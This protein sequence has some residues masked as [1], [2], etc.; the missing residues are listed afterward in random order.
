[1]QYVRVVE[2]TSILGSLGMLGKAETVSTPARSAQRPNVA[3]G[4]Q[5]RRS[6]QAAQ[7]DRRPGQTA[8]CGPG[9]PRGPGSP[10]KPRGPRATAAPRRPGKL[11]GPAGQ[12]IR[13]APAGRASP[14]PPP[15]APA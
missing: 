9:K 5:W 12:A 10:G 11:R 13:A 7:P 2:E 1:M 15:A 14:P 6:Q 4:K 8:A 3:T